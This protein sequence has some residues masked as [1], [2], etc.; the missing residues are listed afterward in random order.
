MNAV[1]R[2]ATRAVW[3]NQ[4]V[5][6]ADGDVESVIHAYHSSLGLPD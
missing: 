3:L 4:G 6:A 2:V 1:R 5:I